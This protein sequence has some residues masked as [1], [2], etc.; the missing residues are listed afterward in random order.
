MISERI[1]NFSEISGHYSFVPVTEDN[2]LHAIDLVMV[3]N[4]NGRNYANQVF[5]P[6]FYINQRNILY[7]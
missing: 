3:I 1:F 6:L 2:L 4:D 5:L 7:L